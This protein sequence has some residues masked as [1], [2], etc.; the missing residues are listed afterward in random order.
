M[1]LG[2]CEIKDFVV[3]LQRDTGEEGEYTIVTKEWSLAMLEHFDYS[4]VGID[5]K[6]K[7]DEYSGIADSWGMKACA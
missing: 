7:I 6:P 5:T 3:L 2:N 4:S 1:E